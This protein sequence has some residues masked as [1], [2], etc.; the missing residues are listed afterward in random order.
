[1][2]YLTNQILDGGV[3]QK[4]DPISVDPVKCKA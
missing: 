3:Y 1:M 2:H 4:A